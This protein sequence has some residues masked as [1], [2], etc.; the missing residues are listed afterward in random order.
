DHRLYLI[1]WIR[2]LRLAAPSRSLSMFDPEGRITSGR[3]DV[4]FFDL[5]DV[6]EARTSCELVF[7]G[8]DTLRRTFGQRLYAT[9][10]QVLY[11]ANN[12]MP[13]RSALSK[14]PI[15]HAL[16]VPADQKLPRDPAGHVERSS[17]L[18]RA[19]AL[20]KPEGVADLIR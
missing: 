18:A 7:E 11:I 14:E 9:V 19:C 5:I 13:G 20:N 2:S 3:V 10:V 6:A 17:I 15:A 8:L 4:D 1:S 16:H 12:L